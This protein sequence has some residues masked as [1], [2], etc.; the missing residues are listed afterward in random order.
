[1]TNGKEN[2]SQSVLIR[3]RVNDFFVFF[4]VAL[5]CTL[6][7]ILSIKR[8]FEVKFSV[9]LVQNWKSIKLRPS[10]TVEAHVCVFFF[11]RFEKHT[12]SISP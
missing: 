11:Q 1:M 12:V 2:P 6:S 7:R 5:L 9:V 10:V 4:L 8:I 3:G